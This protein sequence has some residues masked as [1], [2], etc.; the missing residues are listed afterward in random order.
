MT[1]LENCWIER[2]DRAVRA[3]KSVGVLAI[4]GA[5]ATAGLASSI[6]Y[7]RDAAGRLTA[8][9]YGTNKTIAYTYTAAGDLTQRK[10][11]AGTPGDSDGDGMDDAWEQLYFGNL[12]RNGTG[13]FDGDGM[14]DLAE[15]L[16]GTL[17][18]N[19][20]SVFKI[21]RVTP[22]PGVSALIEWNSVPGKTYRVQYRD[23]LTNGW[24]DLAGDVTATGPTSAKLD[25]TITGVTQRYYRVMI[26]TVAAASSSNTPANYGA[27]LPPCPDELR[28]ETTTDLTPVAVWRIFSEAP[29]GHGIPGAVLEVF[30]SR[31]P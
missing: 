8:V 6:S 30:E 10:F 27:G 16:A 18:N 3:L 5:F 12:S 21:I 22:T 26:V 28:S 17:P 31:S 11:S 7:S 20:S 25:N 9:S 14:S 23:A 4:A 24:T 13:D 15:F 29:S 19:A 1:R 2:R